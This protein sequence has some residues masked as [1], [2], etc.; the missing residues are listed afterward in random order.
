MN[1]ESIFIIGSSSLALSLIMGIFLPDLPLISF[2]KGMLIG[3][4]LVMNINYLI[5]YRLEK[6]GFNENRNN[7]SY[8]RKLQNGS[9]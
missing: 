5:R 4:S 2:L 9:N 6:S 3:I 1:K 8:M 7:N